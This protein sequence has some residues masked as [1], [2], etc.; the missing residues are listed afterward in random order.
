MDRIKFKVNDLKYTVGHEVDSDM[1]LNDYLREVLN[2]RGTKYMCKEGGC[3]ACIVNVRARDH[4]GH[5]RSFSVN[6]CLV[7]ITS[8]HNWEITTIEG[9]GDR[10]RGYHPVQKTLAEHD[11]T[12]C[13]YCS[14]GWVM[15]MYSLLESSNYNLTE[16]EIENSFGSNTCRCTGYRPI[17]DAFKSFAKDHPKPNI[18]DIEDLGVCKNR[19]H[20]SSSCDKSWCMIRSEDADDTIKKLKLKDDRVWYR[21][22]RVQDIFEVLHE[23]GNDSYMLVNGNTGRGAVP[24]LS[25]PRVLIDISPIEEIKGHYIDQNLIVGAG[26]TLTDLM[27]LFDTIS[28]EN[29]DFTYLEKLYEHLDLVAHIP[30]RNIGTIAGNLMVKHRSPT[31][32]SDIFLL[33]ET[34]GAVLIIA[35]KR[36]VQEVTLL[37][38]LS[39]NMTGK[40]LTLIKIP[41]YAANHKFVSFKIMPRSQNAHAQVNAAFLYEFD[42]HNSD[43][44][45]SARIVIGGLSA[46]FVHAYNTEKFLIKKKIFTNSVLQNALQILNDEILTEEIAGE[47]SP[48]FRKKV[49]LGLFYKGLLNLIPKAQLK[50]LYRSGAR[51]FRKTRPMSKGSEIYDTNPLIWPE[52][53]PMPKLDALVQCAG[54]AK[55]VNDIPTQPKEVFCAFVTS[56]ICVG[57]LESIDPSAALKI[58]GV[59]AFFSAKDIP[60]NNSFLSTKVFTQQPELVFAENNI[61]YYDQAIGVIVAETEKLANRAAL[62]VQ[63]KYKVTNRRP[64]LKIEDLKQRDPS[65]IQ[66]FQAIPARDRGLN[67]ERVIKGSNNIFWQ[68]HFTMET[69]SSITLPNEDGIDVFSSTQ[70]IDSVHVGISEVL[71]IEQNK[72]NVIVPRCGG[73]YGIKITRPNHVSCVN[74]LVTHLMNRPSRFVMSI[75]AN[76]RVM[77]RRFPCLS[78]FEI[79]V[80]NNGEIQYLNHNVYEDCGFKLGDV[81]PAFVA[82]SIK[83]CYDSQRWQTNIFNAFTD[84]ASNVYTRGPGSLEGIAVIEYIMEKISYELNKDPVEVRMN[85]LDQDPAVR[86]VIEKLLKDSEYYKRKE[87]VG[88]FNKLNR[89][90]KRGIRVAFMN[91]LIPLSLDFHVLLSV[92][93]GDGTIAIRHGGIEIGQGIN[94]IVTQV[95]AYTLNI[96]IDKIKIKAPESVSIPNNFSIGGSRSTQA[97][98]FGVIKCCQLLLDRLAVVRETLT[99]P[100]W[101]LLITTAYNRGINLQTSYRVTSNDQQPYRSAGATVTE[102]ELDI[103]TGEHEVLRVDILEDVGTS[104]NPKLDIGQIEGA[105]TMGLGYWTHEELMFDEKTGELLTDRT[106]YYHVPLAKDIPIDFRIQLRRNS[107]NPVGTLGSR[108]VSEPPICMAISVAFALR[109]A[110]AASREDSGFPRNQ[111]FDV[112]GAFTLEKNVL[113]SEARLNEFLYQ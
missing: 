50:P 112:P 61:S 41:P 98:C 93:H 18:G 113:K 55:Y 66:L 25:F 109:E 60:G 108:G 58:P 54:E 79:G 59:L 15:S 75:Q 35:D 107:Y 63:V 13:G 53:E 78:E 96:S 81:T 31:F 88:E 83:N 73:A 37:D 10:G 5:L 20:C 8:C 16:H 44:V 26:T 19:K 11:G 94:T 97:I 106:W 74:A 47:P 72:I 17:L 67:V 82:P 23:E 49:A 32:S 38:F 22:K 3:G 99:D 27:E 2:L 39:L 92:Y 69:L 1:S 7:S 62:L 42:R 76:M 33:L 65:R 45:L 90:K 14:P 4:T 104:V 87:E 29:S 48:E 105:F 91:Y 6:S 24:I 89:W 70:W 86:D 12:Q 43:V 30:V 34:I 101:E 80:N 85:N 52:T 100:T 110:I 68:Y 57:E 84:T 56:D 95:V 71:N 64:F 111:W 40:V 77:G 102:V 9:I 21:V 28:K 36:N 103:L 51:D 46:K